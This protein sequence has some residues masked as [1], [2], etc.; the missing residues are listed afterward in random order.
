MGNAEAWVARLQSDPSDAAAYAGLKAHYAS[1]GDVDAVAQLIAAWAAST[2]DDLAAAEAYVELAQLVVQHRPDPTEAEPYYREALRR[3]P[4]AMD[5]LE[6]L[7]ALWSSL[8]D[9]AKLTELL[10][11][12]LHVMMRHDAPATLLAFVRFQLGELWNK[13]FSSPEEAL[14]H[15]RKAAELDPTLTAACYEARQIHVARGELRAASELLER[16]IASE[17]D[18]ERRVALLRELGELHRDS[19]DDLDG[20]VAAFE[21][22]HQLAPEDVELCYEL[23]SVL[24]RRAA[25]LDVRTARD[26]LRKVA[27]LLLSIAAVAQDEEARGYLESALDHAP[28]HEAALAAL[29]RY[30]ERGVAVATLPARWVGY[31]ATGVTGERA[32]ARRVLLARAYLAQG[33]REDALFCL[34]AAAENGHAPATALLAQLTPEPPSKA[35]PPKA[36]PAAAT[37]SAQSPGAASTVPP[38]RPP[39]PSL[40]SDAAKTVFEPTTETEDPEKLAARVAE[41]AP[42]RAVAEPSRSFDQPTATQ[43]TERKPAARAAAAPLPPLEPSFETEGALEHLKRHAAGLAQRRQMDEAAEAYLEVFDLDASDPE[44]FLFLDAHYRKARANAERARILLESSADNALPRT[45]RLTRLREAATLYETRIKNPDGALLAFER[46]HAIDPTADDALRAIRRLLERAARWDELAVA[47]EADFAHAETDEARGT[48]LRRLWALHRD[49]R[50]DPAAVASTLER[51]L[52]LRPEDRAA[53]DALLAV[54]LELN[55]TVEAA[56]LIEQRI[57]EAKIKSQKLA[58]LGQL[59]ELYEARVGDLERAHETY[60]RVLALSPTD[61]AVVDKLIALDERTGNTERLLLT[62]ERRAAQLGHAEASVMLARMAEIADRKLDDPER[63]AELWLRAIEKV[64]NDLLLVDALCALYER[65]DQH[66][67]LVELLRERIVLERDTELKVTL[68]RKL[69]RALNEHLQDPDGAADAYKRLLDLREDPEA[70]RALEQYARA[71]DDADALAALLPRLL[72]IETDREAQRDLLFERAELLTGRL[73][74]P[75]DAI[76]DLERI[77]AGLDVAYEPAWIALAAA[78]ES[79]NDYAALCRA[80][81]QRLAR[82]TDSAEQRACAEQLARIYLHKTRDKARSI[83][84]LQRWAAAAQDEVEPHELLLPLLRAAKKHAELLASLD[85]IARLAATTAGRVEHAIAAA[86]V[87]SKELG[88]ADEAFARLANLTTEGHAAAVEPLIA[89]ANS[90]VKTDSLFDLLERT[91]HIDRLLELLAERAASDDPVIRAA[92]YRRVAQVLI[93]YRS[94]EDGAAAAYSKLLQIDEDIDALR[95]LHAFALKRD[96]PELLASVLGRLA[97]LTRDAEE[98][99]D[100]V[101]IQAQTLRARLERPADAVA[102]LH[103]LHTDRP[104]A[105]AELIACCEAANDFPALATTL[106]RVLAHEPEPSERARIAERIADLSEGPLAEPQRARRALDVW[107]T[108][109]PDDPIPLRRLRPLLRAAGHH[110]ELLAVLDRLAQLDPQPSARIEAT[111]AAAQLA[112]DELRDPSG[113]FD[114]LAALVPAADPGI[115]AALAALAQRTGRV[116]DFHALLQHAERFQTL[117]VEL[118]KH[119]ATTKQRGARAELYRRIGRLRGGPLDDI[120][121]AV[122][123]FSALLAE[124]EDKE[125]LELLR[126]YALGR[127]DIA[128]V[129]NCL[130]R[131]AALETEREPKRDLLYELGHLLRARLDD[132]HGAVKVLREVIEHLDPEFDPALDELVTACE[133]TGDTETLALA[134]ERLSQR[135]PEPE[136]RVEHARRLVPLLLAQGATERAIA[137]LLRWSELVPNDPEP[138]V[139]VVPLLASRERHSEQLTQLD[140]LSTLAPTPEARLQA[141]ADAAEVCLTCLRSP[142]QAFDRLAAT[143]VEAAPEHAPA[144]IEALLIALAKNHHMLPELE[145]LLTATHRYEDVATLLRGHADHERDPDQRAELLRRCA[146]VLAGPLADKVAASEAYEELLRVRDDAEALDHLCNEAR[147][148]DE[149]VK[150]EAL[151][152]RLTSLTA[153]AT[154]KRDLSLERARLLAERLDRPAEAIAL[155]RKL[156]SEIDPTH[157]P[158]IDELLIA[159]ETHGDFDAL[160]YGL[161]LRLALATVPRSQAELAQR[162]A[163]VCEDA[164]HDRARATLA[165][166]RWAEAEPGMPTPLRR[167]RR[168]LTPEQATDLVAVLDRLALCEPD[169]EARAEAQ[170]AS[171]RLARE[172]LRD[173]E[174]ALRRLAPLVL[175]RSPEAEQEAAAL[176]A[177]HASLARPL[178]NLYVMRAQRAVNPPEALND[179]MLAA[180]IHAEQTNEPEEALEAAL[181]ALACDLHNRAVLAEIDKLG[182]TLGAWERLARVYTRLVQHAQSPIERAEIMLRHADLLETQARDPGAALERV[183]EVCKLDPS[184]EV[185]LARAE[186]L[187]ERT[188]HHEALVWIE[189]SLAKRTDSDETRGQRWLKAARAADLGLKDRELAFQYMT[190]VLA[191]TERLPG[192]AEDL[193]ELAGE[194]DR[195]RPELGES[196]ARRGLVRAH[197]ELGRITPEPFGPLLM[198]RASQLYRDELH[199]EPACFDALKDAAALFPDDLEI[200]DALERAGLR[201]QRLDALEAHLSRS[202]QKTRDPEAKI[203]LLERRGRLLAEHL[204]R[205]AKAADAYR[206]LSVLR[207]N[208]TNVRELL[209]ASLHKSGRFQDLLRAYRDQ[210]ERDGSIEERAALLRRIA[211]LWENELRNRPNALA[212]LRELVALTPDDAEAKSSL[213]RL[214]ARSTA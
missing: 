84:A 40:A 191:L 118:D 116:E 128:S 206:E 16:E 133:A 178:A 208:D 26:E 99:L 50:K 15:Y 61:H 140:A 97:A 157:A 114:R 45:T 8:G 105:V 39:R 28:D 27:D 54:Y 79:A 176:G 14:H 123:A 53:R 19:V 172:A 210:V 130:R 24:A 56:A 44:A 201:L 108:A 138:R 59:A 144:R 143:V 89:L 183:L 148:V 189:D 196:D 71:R 32:D 43:T 49:Q 165:L 154:V 47:L 179:W 90:T 35:A 185:S 167:L 18:V 10:Q 6:G 55:R 31:L 158:A 187:A 152:E 25:T 122:A 75:A 129:C 76:L 70:L 83:V 174:G 111:I 156:L 121:G 153:D 117:V 142:R 82:A 197:M 87:L 73:A 149:P 124:Q 151:L 194:L 186:R 164:L 136:R 119:V 23:A 60:E 181:R 5:A 3:D 13:Q 107:A 109:E 92:C 200:Y 211:K 72:N 2:R 159:A 195:K 95:F 204:G 155:L 115:D 175:A 135:E 207:P 137:A 94:D 21:R 125:A 147:E 169:P 65:R 58:L 68:Y 63:A 91:E 20:S 12:Q 145:Q 141:V 80:L 209:Y 57:E 213:S 212:A 69:A 9:Y 42:E 199:D 106:E 150:L 163:D 34:E 139:A 170:L 202:I 146:R 188:G 98:R 81:E 180:R 62:L 74:R 51:L 7:S 166:K 193:E 33:Q 203:A 103:R 120:K 131:L 48:L 134:V 173:P 101:L 46:I 127:D 112:A 96:E 102:A 214:E 64:P 162:L 30:A 85:A 177:A 198:L 86:H 126:T 1:A 4:L 161:D 184:D 113:A 41:M 29:E 205:H 36:P 78:A 88:N 52:E 37:R 160:A 171:A 67:D 22:A 192:I 66:A 11:E 168:L 132:P 77:V 182:V 110:G 100:L 190:R 93:E 104:D 38:P 17:A